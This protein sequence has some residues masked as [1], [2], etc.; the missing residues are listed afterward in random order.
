[1]VEFWGVNHETPMTIIGFS[2][3]GLSLQFGLLMS[4]YAIIVKYLIVDIDRVHS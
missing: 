2:L 1:M 3:N 4:L